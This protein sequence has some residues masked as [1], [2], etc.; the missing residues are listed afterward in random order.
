MRKITIL[1]LISAVL[2][3]SSST[4]I[5]RDLKT[6]DCGSSDKVIV[7]RDATVSPSPVIYPGNVSLG[8]LMDLLEDLPDE[9]LKVKVRVEKLE[10]ERMQVPCMNG[11]G[12][13]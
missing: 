2:T 5:F 1:F 8:V 4:T 12:S 9:N 6:W 11:M 7:F 3:L 13:W 10:P